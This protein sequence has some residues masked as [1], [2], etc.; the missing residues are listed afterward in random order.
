MDECIFCGEL[1]I[2]DCPAYVGHQP[3]H[4][5]CR[6]K[7]EREMSVLDAGFDFEHELDLEQYA[8]DRGQVEDYEI[9]MPW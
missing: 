5:E 7:Y 4:Q 1:I 9:V 6:R 8:N 2:D 3:M